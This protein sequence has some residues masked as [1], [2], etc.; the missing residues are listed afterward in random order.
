[1]TDT[2]PPPT[3]S[4]RKTIAVEPDVYDRLRAAKGADESWSALLERTL[5]AY[6]DVRLRGFQALDID[7]FPGE[8]DRDD[9]DDDPDGG[10]KIVA[11]R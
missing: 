9:T 3:E 4:N 10:G 11:P 7:P 2:D 8:R 6:D 5:D 1:M